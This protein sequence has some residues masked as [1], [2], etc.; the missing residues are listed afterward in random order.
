MREYSLDSLAGTRRGTAKDL[1]RDDFHGDGRHPRPVCPDCCQRLLEVVHPGRELVELGEQIPSQ[2][3]P[4]CVLPCCLYVDHRPCLFW[5]SRGRR[6]VVTLRCASVMHQTF[7]AVDGRR[8]S[9]F[10]QRGGV[11]MQRRRL[12][13]VTH[14]T[15]NPRKV[16]KLMPSLR[17]ARPLISR[18]CEPISVKFITGFR[19]TGSSTTTE[20]AI[21]HVEYWA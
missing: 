13:R 18:S 15:R 6:N 19:H 8:A 3:L 20:V 4:C 17:S 12:E 7:V 2:L 1:L 14:L 5:Y 9:R 16:A 10:G 21:H 11:M